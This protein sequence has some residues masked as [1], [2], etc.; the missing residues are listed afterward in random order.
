MGFGGLIMAHATEGASVGGVDM[1]K[2]EEAVHYVC[3]NCEMAD[4]LGAVKLNNIIYYADMDSYAETGRSITG[5]TYIKQRRGP[6]PREILTAI[7]NLKTAGRLDSQ[8]V[9]VFDLVRREFNARG[10]TDMDALSKDDIVRLDKMIRFVCK[11][12][13]EE[14][15]EISHTIVWDAADLGEVLPYET[16][17]V[18][19][20]GEIT[21][22]DV[23]VAQGALS[24]AA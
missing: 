21:D 14:I 15:S 6:V 18:S 10:A 3:D 16:F 1:R 23:K 24:R 8:N 5:A 20:L 13:A 11:H 4:R 19:Y 12:S 17:L 22:E 9:S 7:E 2:L